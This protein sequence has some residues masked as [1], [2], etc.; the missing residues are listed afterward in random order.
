MIG[1]LFDILVRVIFYCAV[2][3]QIIN[4]SA[5]DGLILCCDWSASN[6]RI[7]SGGEDCKYKV[8]FKI[9]C[10]KDVNN[11]NIKIQYSSNIIKKHNNNLSLM[12]KLN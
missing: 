7:I 8:N 1:Q 4:I 11:H 5:H 9:I 3:G 2:I 6:G 12:E 10:S